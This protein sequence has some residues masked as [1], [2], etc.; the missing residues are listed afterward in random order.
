MSDDPILL[1]WIS[2]AIAGDQAAFEEIYY[3][4]TDDVYTACYRMMGTAQEAE[5]ATQDVFIRLLRVLPRYDPTRASFRTWVLTITT[6]YC[7]DLLRRRRGNDVSIDDED[8]PVALTLSSDDPSPEQA[9][10]GLELRDRI[11]AMLDRLPAQDRAMVVLRYWFDHGYE[12]IAEATET[13]VSA[14]KSRLFRARQKLAE[15]LGD[16]A[17]PNEGVY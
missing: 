3:T 9:T 2:D 17:L 13:S 15:L 7:Y 14:V 5:D 11:Q 8:E 12:E 10:M 16:V 4:Y 6:N 1:E